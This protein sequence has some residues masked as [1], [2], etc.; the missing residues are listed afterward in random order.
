MRVV[1]VTPDAYG[2]PEALRLFELP[3]RHAGPGK[4]RIAVHAA[5]VNPTDTVVRSGL[6]HERQ[7]G[8]DPP[9]VP[10]MDVAGVIDEIGPD[11][12]T[13]LAVG[14]SVM[15]IVMPRGSHGG[16]GDSIVVA[17]TSVART[18]AGRTLVEAAT[19]PMNGLTARRALDLLAVPPGGTVAVTGAAGTLGGY[20]V[21]LAKVDGLR[22]I[23]DAAESDEDL[24]AS[25]GADAVV[26]RGDDVARRIREV[27]PGGV[28]ALVDAAL[29]G[30]LVLP[31][32]RDGGALAA[33]RPSGGETERGITV[34][35]VWVR[36]YRHEQAKLDR[37]R[38]LV[39]EGRLTLRVAGVFP[40][41][42]A[43][44]AH[45][46]LERG[47]TRGRLVIRFRADPA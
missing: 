12:G 10:G 17:P 2:G 28:D 39:E 5:A 45:A 42:Q 31:A 18:P 20:V 37:L 29:L 25:F 13:G 8:V 21:Q 3:D 33:V 47:G 14:E 27:A 30:A 46:R 43:G 11:T 7:Q 6:A 44:E 36:D 19:L 35:Q 34:H 24:V 26:R 9:Y 38:Q 22:V 15:A 40:P 32:V 4:I 16:Y 1:G 23:A 41:D